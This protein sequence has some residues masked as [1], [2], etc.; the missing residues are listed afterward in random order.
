MTKKFKILLNYIKDLS[1][2]KDLK[3]KEL[4]RIIL[5]DIQNKIYPEL[6]KV[7]LNIIK[8]SGFPNLILEKKVDFEK[9][10]NQK[11]N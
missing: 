9:L 4:E 7:F 10:Y 2:D 11:Y 6:E 5:V 8:N 3:K 1:I